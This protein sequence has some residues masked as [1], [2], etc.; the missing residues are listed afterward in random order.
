MSTGALM[1][2]F[3]NSG[4]IVANL[5]KYSSTINLLYTSKIHSSHSGLIFGER[6]KNHETFGGCYYYIHIPNVHM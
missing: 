3:R 2:L 5:S 6:E 4:T 1:Q